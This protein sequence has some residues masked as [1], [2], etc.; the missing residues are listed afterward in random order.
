MKNKIFFFLAI[1]FL[2]EAV[3]DG[4]KGNSPFMV[5]FKAGFGA[6]LLYGFIESNHKKEDK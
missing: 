2:I 5:G 4:I 1:P 3:I 6:V